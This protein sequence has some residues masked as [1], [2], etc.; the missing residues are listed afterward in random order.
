[1]PDIIEVSLILHSFLC[2]YNVGWTTAFILA[3][4]ILGCVCITSEYSTSWCSPVNVKKNIKKPDTN[5][6]RNNF[7][8]KMFPMMY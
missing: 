4:C 8:T 3:V 7:H 1:M 5:S 6:N 2:L